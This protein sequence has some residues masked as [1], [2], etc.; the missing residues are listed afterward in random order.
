MKKIWEIIKAFVTD[1]TN[2]LLYLLGFGVAALIYILVAAT[3]KWW[4]ATLIGAGISAIV[5]LIIA[6]ARKQNEEDKEK[7]KLK[8]S[9]L[10]AGWLGTLLLV[11]ASF[12]NLG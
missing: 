10:V 6:F 1:K 8:A 5:I 2:Q 11:I 9:D 3:Q 7:K 4:V 12:V